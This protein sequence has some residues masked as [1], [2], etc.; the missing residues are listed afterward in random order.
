ML[1]AF[2]LYELPT[3]GS[4]ITEEPQVSSTLYWRL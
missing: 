2:E 3:R 4:A 1:S